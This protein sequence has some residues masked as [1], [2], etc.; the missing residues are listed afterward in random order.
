MQIVETPIF[1]RRVT[2]LLSDEEYRA[3]QAVLLARPD[4]G[5]VIVGTGGARKVRW[6]VEGR[7]KSGGMRAIYYWANAR[8][9]RRAEKGA[10]RDNRKNGLRDFPQLCHRQLPFTEK[11]QCVTNF[12]M[13]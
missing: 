8:G 3:L 4:V 6:A 11:P 9:I 5:R 10:P 1:T 2:E 12:S 13:S 7:G